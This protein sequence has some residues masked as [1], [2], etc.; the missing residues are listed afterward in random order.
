MI[1]TLIGL[2][3]PAVL[4]FLLVSIL[5]RHETRVG[6]LERLCLSYPLG[7][8][9]VTVQ[10]FLLGILRIPLTL[11]FV[12]APPFLEIIGLY[13]WIRIRK[14]PLSSRP[15]FHLFSELLDR[16]ASWLKKSALIA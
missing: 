15:S 4:G 2:T 9:I 6:V 11:W 3:L 10:M 1:F 8:G 16:N 14:I 7:A 12:A 13:L 5:L